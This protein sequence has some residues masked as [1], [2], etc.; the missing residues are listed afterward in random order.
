MTDYKEHKINVEF[1]IKS[2][3]NTILNFNPIVGENDNSISVTNHPTSS[4][5]TSRNFLNESITLPS[6]KM[7]LLQGAVA[8]N[9]VYK[10]LELDNPS[11]ILTAIN[12]LQK[13]IINNISQIE[14]SKT[15]NKEILIYK[16]KSSGFSNILIDEDGDVSYVFVGKKL[17]EE[18]TA[19]FSKQ[20]GLDYQKIAELL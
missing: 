9:H 13:C 6:R 19:Y 11:V 15:G 8:L 20:K 2:E 10:E 1:C 12:I 16:Q 7:R 4:Y 3:D 5:R 18:K 14:I 17:G